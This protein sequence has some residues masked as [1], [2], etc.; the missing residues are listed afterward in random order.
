LLT[1]LLIS[2]AGCGVSNALGGAVMAPLTALPGTDVILET[3][4]QSA[5]EGGTAQAGLSSISTAAGNG[6][7]LTTTGAPTT[8]E[9][10]SVADS[11]GVS[12]YTAFNPADDHC[13]GLFVIRPGLLTPVLGET[14]AGTYYFWF[15]STKAVDCTASIFTA[16]LTVP[17]RWASGDP[18]PTGWPNE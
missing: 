4:L 9:Q 12:L 6:G 1:V 18:S 5:M 10:V 14:T 8:P 3:N 13:L 17:S 7:G 15:G 2:L 16:E 11:T